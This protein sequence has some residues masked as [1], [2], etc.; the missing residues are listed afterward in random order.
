VQVRFL[1]WAQA[2]KA[3]TRKCGCFFCA[4]RNWL[5]LKF[6]LDSNSLLASYSFE[7]MKYVRRLIISIVV[8]ILLFFVWLNLPTSIVHYSQIKE[9]NVYVANLFEYQKRN[10]KLPNTE[11]IAVLEKLSP[12]KEFKDWFPNYKKTSDTSFMLT[13]FEGFDPPYLTYDSR[14]KKWEMK[15]PTF[16]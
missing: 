5:A 4:R 11:D 6:A 3:V 14:S 1:F 15:F 16:P 7:T 9:G 8:L 10:N 2:L 13:Y 12:A